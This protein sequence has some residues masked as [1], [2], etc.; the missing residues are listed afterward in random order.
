VEAYVFGIQNTKQEIVSGQRQVDGKLIFDFSLQVK[1]G[2][3][4]KGPVFAG[5]FASGPVHDRFIWD[6]QFDLIGVTRL[7][8]YWRRT[9]LVLSCER[10]DTIGGQRPTDPDG[11]E[12]Q[13]GGHMKVFVMGATG[14]IGRPLI[15][16]LLAAHHDV[17][18]M[19]R[20]N[21]CQCPRLP[22]G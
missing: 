10:S 3:D 14:A 7:K 20:W 21:R 9:C 6:P 15:S 18:G 2:A 22:G 11:M 16:A 17:V 12:E 5:R 19:T 1:P 4:P 8:L 13:H